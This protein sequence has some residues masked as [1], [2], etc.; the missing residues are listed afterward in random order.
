MYFGVGES[1]NYTPRIKK[2]GKEGVLLDDI[3]YTKLR[4]CELCGKISTPKK[5]TLRFCVNGWDSKYS[6][7]FH[8]SKIMLCMGCLNK[9]RPVHKA[10]KEAE[11]IKTLTGRLYKEVLKCQKLQ[12][13]V[14]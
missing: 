8:M 11:R 12:K 10:K 14:N 5:I 3:R 9:V 1:F 2:N 4:K 6:Y 7:K 13:Q